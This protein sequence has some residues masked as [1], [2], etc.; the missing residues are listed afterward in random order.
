MLQF[1]FILISVIGVLYFSVAK[2]QFDFFTIGFFSACVYFLPG[3]FG[4]ALYPPGTEYVT[5][6]AKLL[7]ETYMVMVVLLVAILIGAQFFY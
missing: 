7:D 6:P 1:A 5:L 3:Y 2:R 4:F